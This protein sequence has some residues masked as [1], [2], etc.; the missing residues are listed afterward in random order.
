MSE[1]VWRISKDEAR[2]DQGMVVARDPRAARVGVEVLR[3]GGNAVDAAVT[4]AFAL[5]VVEPVS[6][7]LGGGGMMV[8]HDAARARTAVVDYAMDAPLAAAPDTFDLDDGTGASP[9]GWRKVKDDANVVG[10][11]SVSIPGLVR[12]LDLAL[13]EFGTLPLSQALEPAIRFAEEGVE[14]DATLAFRIAMAMP[15]LSRFPAT[16]ELFLP[17]GFPLRNGSGFV[18]TDRLVQ[19]DLGRTLRRIAEDGPDYFYQGE[20]ARRIVGHLRDHGSL[21]TDEDLA[22]YRPTVIDSGLQTT[23]RGCQIVGVPGAC[24]SV[25]VQQGLNILDGFDLPALG[26]GTVE[27]LH[28]DAEAFRRAFADR[29]RYVGDP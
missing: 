11:R 15:V 28:L 8:V 17:R 2:G 5:A 10:H 4:M 13:T 21:M 29:Y 7:G 27:A 19:S 6:S 24:G 9:Y 20:T 12:G 23:Y 18:A 25:T 3:R 14:V 26:S 16:A 22:R 1:S